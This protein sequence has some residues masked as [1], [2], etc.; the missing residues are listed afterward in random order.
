MAALKLRDYL[1]VPYILEAQ[2]IEIGPDRWLRKL[3]YPEL[4]DFCA[5]A[6]IVEVALAELERMRIRAIVAGLREGKEPP[7][8]RAPLRSA[9][10]EWLA[11]ELG[12]LAENRDLLDKTADE[13]SAGDGAR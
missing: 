4:G 2:G 1:K 6:E 3:S 13:I 12:I 10:P 5:E 8:P 7:M 9:D 11:G